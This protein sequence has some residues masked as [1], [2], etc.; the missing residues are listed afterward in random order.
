MNSIIALIWTYCLYLLKLNNFIPDDVFTTG[1]TIGVAFTGIWLS[2]RINYRNRIIESKMLSEFIDNET[3]VIIDELDIQ[4]E[5]EI[6][7]N[8]D[9]LRNE[10]KIIE[11]LNYSGKLYSTVKSLLR[12]NNENIYNSFITHRRVKRKYKK[13]AFGKINSYWKTL[14]LL[15]YSAEDMIKHIFIWNDKLSDN[16]KEFIELFR[17]LLNDIYVLAKVHHQDS[18]IRDIITEMHRV[19]FKNTKDDILKIK[20]LSLFKSDIEECRRIIKSHIKKYGGNENLN[21]VLRRC[22]IIDD[23]IQRRDI[24][25]SRKVDYFIDQKERNIERQEEIREFIDYFSSIKFKS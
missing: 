2:Y 23:N 8:I 24:I 22:A 5:K 11:N 4:N 18:S 20:D 7:K 10:G 17:D 19:L 25:Q 1:I 13:I 14:E 15:N 12:I 6:K 21:I 9:E 16:N 3:T